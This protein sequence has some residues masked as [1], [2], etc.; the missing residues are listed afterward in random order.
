MYD[1]NKTHTAIGNTQTDSYTITLSTTPVVDGDSGTSTFGGSLATATEN[2]QYDV[3]TFI[4]G[5]VIPSKTKIETAVLATSGTS[6]SGSE[7]SFTKSTTNRVV[8]IG[9]NYYWTSNNLVA[10]GIN[11]TNEMSGT[12]SLSVPI[13]LTSEIDSLSP[14]LDLQRMSMIAVSNQI[15]Q[16]DSSS[17]VYPTSTYKAMTEP[18]GD[19]HSAIYL[20]KKIE[21][22]TPATSL[23]VILDARRF[24]KQILN[25][26]LKLYELMM[27]LTLRRWVLDFLTMMELSLGLV[28]QMS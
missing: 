16:I 28:G 19:N 17:D 11:E 18:E 5:T 10:S 12:K 14:V 4:M 8:P 24:P 3:S 9:D 6:P 21:L 7:T 13:T 25:Y 27:H 20:T 2:A 15:N 23:R 26:C 1:I 22:E